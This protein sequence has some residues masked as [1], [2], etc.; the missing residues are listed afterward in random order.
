MVCGYQ[1]KT[2]KGKCLL[3]VTGIMMFLVNSMRIPTHV[4]FEK[5]TL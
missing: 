4:T 5:L 1:E 2:E 3:K